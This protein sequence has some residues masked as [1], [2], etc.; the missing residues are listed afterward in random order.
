MLLFSWVSLLATAGIVLLLLENLR[1]DRFTELRT[2]A[3]AFFTTLGNIVLVFLA[4]S[5]SFQS[6]S[7]DL[8]RIARGSINWG[9]ILGFLLFLYFRLRNLWLRRRARPTT[10]ADPSSP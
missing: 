9:I 8:A 5:L 3:T 4:Y 2:A 7:G 10:A 6:I 1:R